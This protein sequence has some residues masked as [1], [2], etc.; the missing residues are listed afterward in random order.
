[1]ENTRK[2]PV[3]QEGFVMISHGTFI[4]HLLCVG[5]NSRYWQDNWE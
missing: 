5:H 3:T 4:E 1:M 2:N